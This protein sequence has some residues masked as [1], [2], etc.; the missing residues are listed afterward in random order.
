MESAV[1]QNYAPKSNNNGNKLVPLEK[2]AVAIHIKANYKGKSF[3]EEEAQVLAEHVFNFFKPGIDRIID[4]SLLPTDRDIFYILE[5]ASLLGIE[6]EDTILYDSREWHI[7][8]WFMKKDKIIEA[9]DLYFQMKYAPQPQKKEENIYESVFQ[10][11]KDSHIGDA[12]GS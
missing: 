1:M 6:K 3:S 12:N 2:L 4:N 10:Q 8:Y 5:D 11:I 7:H 9:A